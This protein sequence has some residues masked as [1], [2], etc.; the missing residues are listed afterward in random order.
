[1]S[2]RELV[3]QLSDA[4]CKIESWRQ[5]YNQQ[6]PHSSLDYLPPAEFARTQAEMSASGKLVHGCWSRELKRRP[7]L[8]TSSPLKHE[9]RT[10][11]G[12]GTANGGTSVLLLGLLGQS[13]LQSQ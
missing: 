4:R 1:M 12:I 5:D 10:H 6:R 13:C 11:I 7:L 9:L 8:Q 2:E 3:H